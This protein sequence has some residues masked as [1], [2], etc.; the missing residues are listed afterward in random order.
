[1]SQY[2]T[3]FIL[4]DQGLVELKVHESMFKS[5]NRDYLEDFLKCSQMHAHCVITKDKYFNEVK[6][7]LEG[8]GFFV[9]ESVDLKRS[10]NK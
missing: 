8:Y 6:P 5:D 7:K 3:E 2:H 10:N 1:M 9:H 4:N